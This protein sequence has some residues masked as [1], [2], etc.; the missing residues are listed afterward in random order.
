MTSQDDLR[1]AND[2]RAA[3]EHPGGDGAWLQII[4][5]A[6][7][8]AAF[9]GWA[10]WATVEESTTGAGQVIP[11]SQTQV[12]QTLDGGIVRDIRVREGDLVEAGQVLIEVDDTGLASTLGEVRSRRRSLEAQISR[13]EAEADGQDA[14]SFAAKLSE[15]AG[16]SVAAER[17]AFLSRQAQRIEETEILRQQLLQ[18]EQELRELRAN[19]ARLQATLEPLDR[20]V[21]L[22]R[23]L[24]SRGAVPQIELLRLERQF[25]EAKGQLQ[26]TKAALP[27][28]ESAIDEARR[29]V[30]AVNLRFRAEAREKLALALAE[31]AVLEETE[32]GA[33]DRV[34][35]TL[36]RA[37]VR[38][39]VNR[40]NVSTIGAVVRPAIDIVEITPLDD[41][42]LIEARVRPQD[43]AFIRPGQAASVKLTAYDFLVY[44]DIGGTV[45]R[46]SADTIEDDQG[47][48]FYRVIVK[49][50]AGGLTRSGETIEILPG[51]VATVDILTGKKTVLD[52]LMKPVLR[53]G[54]EALRER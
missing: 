22:T 26:V 11:S 50:E 7:M 14:V 3:T 17:A 32:R 15:Q 41:T 21:E 6:L 53:V 19:E 27:R 38:G 16:S 10:N 31:L 1:F 13:L 47:N 54:S 36:L 8:F 35:R 45:E 5:I 30:D 2:A 4:V 49:T 51:M 9:L 33:A 37:P 18:R 20:E 52:Y 29:R 43:V 24:S 23:N 28:A 40:L 25:A 42:L 44:G 34:K 46:I 39:I 48:T 12:V